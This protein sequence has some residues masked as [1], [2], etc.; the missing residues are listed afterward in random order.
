MIAWPIAAAKA[1]GL[2]EHIVVSTDDPEIAEIARQA[3]AET[4]F[5]RPSALADDHTG[6]V[7]VVQHAL[8]WAEQEGWAVEAACCLYATAAFTTQAELGAAH[9]LLV[10]PCEYVF[11]ALRYG[12]P[13]QR[14]FVK[15]P[16]GDPRLL[17]PEHRATRTQDLPPVYHDAGQFYWGRAQAF[18]ENRPFFD[19]RTR[20][21]EVPQTRAW[22]IDNEE[23]WTI[24]EALFA[25]LRKD[26]R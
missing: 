18:I 10:E 8:A 15:G 26:A 23:D 25:G 5:E 13:P 21:I 16:E 7:E 4:P 17:Q 22:D 20:F 3:G 2:F 11:P 6:T 24:A 14:G 9:A 19:T 12:H 1:S